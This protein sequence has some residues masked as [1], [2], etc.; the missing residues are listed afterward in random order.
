M[1]G[2]I[3]NGN[4]ETSFKNFYDGTTL[5]PNI[6]GFMNSAWNCRIANEG[7]AYINNFDDKH[8]NVKKFATLFMESTVGS[9]PYSSE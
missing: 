4:Y 2:K 8:L 3:F 7:L 6:G 5:N 9:E 1:K